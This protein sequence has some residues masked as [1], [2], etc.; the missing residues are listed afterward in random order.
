MYNKKKE[1]LKKRIRFSN[2]RFGFRIRMKFLRKYNRISFGR[3]I[4]TKTVAQLINYLS[5]FPSNYFVAVEDGYSDSIIPIRPGLV[6]G[7]NTVIFNHNM[8]SQK[9]DCFYHNNK[10]F[11]YGD[12][13][14]WKRV[15]LFDDGTRQ[16][17]HYYSYF[18]KAKYE[19]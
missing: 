15:P 10:K 14:F 19:K 8:Y 11:V 3:K 1:I 2:T 17:F 7:L 16:D 13:C 18:G 12:V 4:E 6:D 5:K 9:P